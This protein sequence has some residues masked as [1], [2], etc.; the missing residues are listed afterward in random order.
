MRVLVYMVRTLSESWSCGGGDG[1]RLPSE[2]RGDDAREVSREES[3][4]LSSEL[5]VSKSMAVVWVG[6]DRRVRKVQMRRCADSGSR[7]QCGL[8]RRQWHA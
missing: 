2:L 8:A 4:L 5:Q 3:S 1:V 7:G 6:G